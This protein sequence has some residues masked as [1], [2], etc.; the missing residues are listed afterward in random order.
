MSVLKEMS[1]MWVLK[2]IGIL[3]FWAILVVMTCYLISWFA[4][5]CTMKMV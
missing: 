3:V 4:P 5:S 2:A 1:V